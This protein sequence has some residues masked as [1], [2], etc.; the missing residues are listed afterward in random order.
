MP[1]QLLTNQVQSNYSL[2]FELVD[3][4]TYAV[5]IWVT[6]QQLYLDVE[7]SAVR[8]RF[9]WSETAGGSAMGLDRLLH[10]STVNSI[11]WIRSNHYDVCV[12]NSQRVTKHADRINNGQ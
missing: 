1:I 8:S 2:P 9:R 7:W 4:V 10:V 6:F 11:Q 3:K 12:G 5:Q